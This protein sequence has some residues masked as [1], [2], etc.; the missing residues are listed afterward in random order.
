MLD[1][2]GEVFKGLFS[3]IIILALIAVLIFGVVMLNNSFWISLLIWIGGIVII[4]LSAGL[5]SIFISIKDYLYYIAQNIGRINNSNVL[6]NN[7]T[8]SVKNNSTVI[9]QKINYGDKWTCKKCNESNPIT[10]ST[11]KGCGEYK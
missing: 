8:N 9:P 2:I 7:N 4:I 10:A 6:Q 1:F 3:F 5:V 11:C